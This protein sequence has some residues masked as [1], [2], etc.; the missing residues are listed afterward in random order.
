MFAGKKKYCGLFCVILGIISCTKKDLPQGTRMSVLPKANIAV[1][2]VATSGK[3]IKISEPKLNHNWSQNGGNSEHSYGN[4]DVN[5][6]P[7]KIWSKKFGKAAG[8]RDIII[9]EPIVMEDKVFALDANAILSSFDL[10]TGNLLWKTKILSH[11]AKKSDVSVKSSGIA[12][13]ASALFVTT[14]FGEVVALDINSGKE[15]WRYNASTPIRIAP[16]CSADKLFI[17]TIDNRLIALNTSD[18]EELW[19]YE[20]LQ[21][22]TTL[23]GG[24]SPALDIAQ[25]ILIAAFSNGEIQALKAS[26][27]S[28][29]WN[30][31]LISN[32]YAAS[33]SAITAIKANPV[34]DNDKVYAIGNGHTFAAI[35]TRTGE[36]IWDLPISGNYQPV[37]SGKYVFVISDDSTLYAIDNENGKIIWQ[38]KLPLSEG[39]K[40][41]LFALRPLLVDGYILATISDGRVFKISATDGTIVDITDLGD[42]IFV[43]PIVANKHLIFST[44]NAELIIFK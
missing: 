37:V 43:S 7:Q 6:P 23:L 22:D 15:M 12:A 18:G 24:A 30:N 20:I 35:E 1:E 40:E 41:N 19:N 2:T 3:G 5:L 26:T 14:G 31:F 36:R 27:G 44:A 13:N 9:S 10:N 11:K 21:E 32:K 16:T 39:N 25:D 38:Q 17:Q 42:E 34:I 28:P 29:L 33:Q 4:L 8:K